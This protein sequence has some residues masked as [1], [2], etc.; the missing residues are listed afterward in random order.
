MSGL[1]RLCETL[2]T[3]AWQA[4]LSM[5]FSRPQHWSGLPCPLPRDLPDLGIEPTSLTSPALAGRFWSH[6]GNLKVNW[7]FG[8]PAGPDTFSV[9]AEQQSPDCCRLLLPLPHPS[10]YLYRGFRKGKPRTRFP[11]GCASAIN[12]GSGG[13]SMKRQ[14]E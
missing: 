9:P 6:P 3:V 1:E 8:L 7:P 11:Q 12:M 2:W 10:P 14:P 4:L 5:G 13:S